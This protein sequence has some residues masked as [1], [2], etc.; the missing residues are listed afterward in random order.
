M[1]KM[2]KQNLS[3]A[4]NHTFHTSSKLLHALLL[5]SKALFPDLKIVQYVP[6]LISGQQL[7]EDLESIELELKKQ[8]SLLTQIHTE[9]KFGCIPKE[10]EEL[11]WEVQRIITQLKVYCSNPY[12]NML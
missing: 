1:N 10:R 5:H 4:L 12:I 2:T 3:A 11:L 8:E 6:P 9:M 7:P